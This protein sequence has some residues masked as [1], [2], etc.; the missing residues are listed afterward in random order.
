M[1][2]FK[3]K[4]PINLLPNDDDKVY[5]FTVTVC[6]SATA[7][8]GWLKYGDS[9]D[10]V[11]ATTKTEAGT[12]ASGIVDGYSNAGNIVYVTMSYPTSLSAGRYYLTLVVNSTEGEVHEIPFEMLDVE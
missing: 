7:N 4:E 12:T 8:D 9:V 11:V 2:A 6:S 5:S 3:G 1:H 10:S